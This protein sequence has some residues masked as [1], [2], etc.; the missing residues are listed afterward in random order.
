M[1]SKE[2]G[3]YLRERGG[4]DPCICRSHYYFSVVVILALPA[5]PRWDQRK[6]GAFPILETWVGGC[7]QGEGGLGTHF[8][9]NQHPH[10]SDE[11]SSIFSHHLT[12]FCTGCKR[13][14]KTKRITLF[15]K[16]RFKLIV[17]RIYVKLV[18]KYTMKNSETLSFSS[19]LSSLSGI[20][21]A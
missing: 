2:R 5:T 17:Q 1:G 15:G 4:E 3:G 9:R 20:C 18:C 8:T 6:K 12:P 16:E 14:K 13:K 19:F 21:P 11:A 10:W 7:L